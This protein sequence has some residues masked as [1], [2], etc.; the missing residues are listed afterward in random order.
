MFDAYIVL[1]Y[2][3]FPYAQSFQRRCWG[4]PLGVGV[5]R[6]QMASGHEYLSGDPQRQSP[7]FLRGPEAQA[8]V[9]FCA[10]NREA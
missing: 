8:L 6:T 10:K 1:S 2:N 5:R 7:N 3:T 4:V 9:A